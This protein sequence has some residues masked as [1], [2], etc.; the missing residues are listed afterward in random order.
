M[1]SNSFFVLLLLL[2]CSS[3][4]INAYAQV[5]GFNFSSGSDGS[6]GALEVTEDTE[7]PLPED[8]VLHFT[9]VHIHEGAKLTFT[10]NARN[11]PVYFLATGNVT[12]DGVISVDGTCVSNE[13]NQC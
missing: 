13:E 2:A 12:I 9:T 1:K 6:M 3:F 4:S 8:G 10:P 5:D 11:T 7:Y